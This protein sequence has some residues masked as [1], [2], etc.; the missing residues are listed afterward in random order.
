MG[1]TGG[2]TYCN[3]WAVNTEWDWIG[4]NKM[5]EL[6]VATV[7]WGYHVYVA[8][9]EAAVRQILPCQRGG[10]NIVDP[11]AVAIMEDNDTPI[12]NG[13]PVLNKNFRS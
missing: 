2:R 7:D 4:A 12:D 9:R 5:S 3:A 11:Y 8:A 6:K 10:G 13:V 1:V